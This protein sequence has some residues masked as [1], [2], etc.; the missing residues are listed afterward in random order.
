LVDEVSL[1]LQV[2]DHEIS[3]D[4]ASLSPTSVTCGDIVSGSAILTNIG[5][6]TEDVILN[7]YNTDLGVSFTSQSYEIDERESRNDQ[8]VSFDF[9]I[10]NNARAG[11]Y[12]VYFKARYDGETIKAIPLTVLSCEPVTSNTNQDD[13]IITTGNQNTLGNVNS[14]GAVTYT[15]QG[16]SDR[17]ALGSSIPTSVWVLIDVLLGVLILVAIVWLFKRH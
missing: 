4:S 14:N 11:L 17:F 7:V 16:T 12:Q 13:T 2:P 5:D 6:N 1:D 8:V 10:P 3:I 9:T 15:Q